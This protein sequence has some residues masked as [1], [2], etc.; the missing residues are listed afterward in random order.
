MSTNKRWRTWDRNP[1]PTFTDYTY[2]SYK[3]ER[4]ES[5]ENCLDYNL[6]S[7][8]NANDVKLSHPPTA[9][10]VAMVVEAYRTFEEKCTEISKNTRRKIEMLEASRKQKMIELGDELAQYIQEKVNGN[11]TTNGTLQT[12]LEN[13]AEQ[14]L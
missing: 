7:F 3:G 6:T 2:V 5:F 4:I 1:E 10:E 8:L 13:Q 11:S 12:R 9:D 14:P